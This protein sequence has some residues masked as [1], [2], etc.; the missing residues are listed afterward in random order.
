[1]VGSR[2][3]S[4]P[5]RGHHRRPGVGEIALLRSRP[6]T[7]RA[8][9]SRPAFVGP[10]FPSPTRGLSTTAGN[11][12]R[13][14]R[15]GSRPRART[16]PV[17]LAV[18]VASRRQFG[19]RSGADGVRLLAPPASWVVLAYADSTTDPT[20]MSTPSGPGYS[21][22]LA[23]V[24]WSAHPVGI[25]PGRPGAVYPRAPSCWYPQGAPPGRDGWGSRPLRHRRWAAGGHGL[26]R[27]RPV[28]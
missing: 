10:A 7:G 26:I 27:R 21:V 3:V 2:G 16:G 14:C 12:S 28:R 11:R 19:R 23:S 25:A 8:S 1:M 9:A 18:P 13:C 22:H 17:S 20:T 6:R 24:R 4:F 15:R 5:E